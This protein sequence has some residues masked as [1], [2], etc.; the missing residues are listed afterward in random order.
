MFTPLPYESFY[1]K[2]QTMSDAMALMEAGHK[3]LIPKVKSRLTKHECQKIRSG[4]VFVWGGNESDMVRWTDHLSWTSSRLAT[5]SLLYKQEQVHKPKSRR[6]RQRKIRYEEVSMLRQGEDLYKQTYY[7]VM[8]NG[9]KLNL[10]AYFYESDLKKLKHPFEDDEFLRNIASSR[11]DSYEEELNYANTGDL[12]LETAAGYVEQ[13]FTAHVTPSLQTPRF[14]HRQSTASLPT[15]APALPHSPTSPPSPIRLPPL[16]MLP[17][18]SGQLPDPSTFSSDEVAHFVH[19]VKQLL[20]DARHQLPAPSVAALKLATELRQTQR[21]LLETG[22]HTPMSI[23]HALIALFLGDG[24]KDERDAAGMILD[25][26]LLERDLM[27][28]CKII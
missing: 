3:G 8:D 26:V 16:S 18:L 21:E 6:A 1:G 17:F 5:S 27:S 11:T 9:E 22:Q 19:Q 12:T 14:P 25:D 23:D 10:V 4:S 20:E 2:V 24:D 7:H 15:H 13:P 28:P